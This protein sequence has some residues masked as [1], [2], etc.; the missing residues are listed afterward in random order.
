MMEMLDRMTVGYRDLEKLKL[1]AQSF[2]AVMNAN[3]VLIFKAFQNRMV[4][5]AF[6][7]FCHSIQEIYDKVYYFFSSRGIKNV[8]FLMIHN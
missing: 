8:T 7:V 6:D 3:I 4:I 5:P 2:R 1:D